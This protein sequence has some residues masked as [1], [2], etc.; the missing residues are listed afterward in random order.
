[1]GQKKQIKCPFYLWDKGIVL[2]CTGFGAAIECRKSFKTADMKLEYMGTYCT[3]CFFKCPF[4]IELNKIHKR[5]KVSKC[6][7][8]KFVECADRAKCTACGWN[9]EVANDRL[10]RIKHRLEKGG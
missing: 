9:P 3:G 5:Y 6:R 7:H 10:E 4:S 2:S 8:N 1:M